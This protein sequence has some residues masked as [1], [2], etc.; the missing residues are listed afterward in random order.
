[1]MRSTLGRDWKPVAAAHQSGRRSQ[2][3]CC[4][5]E[6][7]SLYGPE[8]TGQPFCGS[9]FVKVSGDCPSHTCLGT[10]GTPLP[11]L[12]VKYEKTKRGL[13]AVS[14]MCAVRLSTATASWT[15]FFRSVE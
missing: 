9:K 11:K 10:I 5:V 8:N 14:A 3:R 4:G 15:Q 12:W 2:M 6:S 13:G 7:T 1:M